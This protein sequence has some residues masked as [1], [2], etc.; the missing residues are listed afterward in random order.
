MPR[1]EESDGFTLDT[2][3]LEIVKM[4]NRTF[5]KLSEWLQDQAGIARS[6]QPSSELYEIATVGDIGKIPMTRI[7]AFIQDLIDMRTT[8][9]N[10]LNMP[11]DEAEITHAVGLLFAGMTPEQKATFNEESA[12]V[13]RAN[14]V[15]MIEQMRNQIANPT[16][17]KWLDNGGRKM[18][19]NITVQNEAGETLHKQT[20]TH[21]FRR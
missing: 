14:I 21:N 12:K 9:N 11:I 15:S 4:D 13:L 19:A 6:D 2:T 10:A 1:I 17:M 16:I 18:I 8:A 3:I 5:L 7:D 20:E